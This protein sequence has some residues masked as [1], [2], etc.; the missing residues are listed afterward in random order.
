[1]TLINNNHLN[2]TK[3]LYRGTSRMRRRINHRFTAVSNVIIKHVI[4]IQNPIL[5]KFIYLTTMKIIMFFKKYLQY[6]E[7]EVFHLSGKS[8]INGN[9]IDLLYVGDEISIKYL[10]YSIFQYNDVVKTSLGRVTTS[11]LLKIINPKIPKVD[12]IVFERLNNEKWVPPFG[13]W[14]RTP[15]SVQMVY[16]RKSDENIESFEKRDK[17]N[18]RTNFNKVKKAGFYPIQSKSKEDLELFYKR[19]HLPLVKKKYGE[20]GEIIPLDHYQK[21]LMSSGLLLFSCLPGG[22][23]VAGVILVPSGK[24]LYGLIFGVLDADEQLYQIGALSSIY[25]FTMEYAIAHNYLRINQGGVIPIKTDGVYIHKKRWGLHPEDNPWSMT[26]WLFWIP[27]NSQEAFDWI[28]ANQFLP[29]FAKFHG[30][31]M[32]LI[33]SMNE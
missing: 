8:G 32:E 21:L 31:Q 9:Q 29:Q 18:N 3:R 19:M 16:Q 5:K 23:K 2:L 22:E 24:T 4:E 13:E 15:R 10:I 11:T 25:I 30:D 1:M 33:Y 14:I 20:L 26:D 17:K 28:K 7:L 12:L 27:N 6:L